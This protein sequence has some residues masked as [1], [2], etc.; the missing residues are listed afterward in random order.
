MVVRKC[1]C[2][3]SFW[4]ASLLAVVVQV[5]LE[6]A[7]M[8]PHQVVRYLEER[9]IARKDLADR[10]GVTEAAI[11]YWVKQGW[12]AF[13]RQCHIQVELRGSGLRASWDDV[14]HDKR[15]AERVA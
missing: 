14:P 7:L 13:D 3:L 5:C 2:V 12:I 11:Y 8:T 6:C 1:T 10:L 15:P 9:R 4:L